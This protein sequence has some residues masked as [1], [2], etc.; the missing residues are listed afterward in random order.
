VNDEDKKKAAKRATDEAIA[1]TVGE[2]RHALE[3]DDP[4]GPTITSDMLDAILG[5]ASNL[6]ADRIKAIRDQ[7]KEEEDVC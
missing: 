1:Q 5:R 4:N 7:K 6:A 3:T 2:F